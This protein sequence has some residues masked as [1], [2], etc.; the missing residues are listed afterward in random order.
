MGYL[1]RR[2]RRILVAAETQREVGQSLCGCESFEDLSLVSEALQAVGSDFHIH[3]S[4]G[5]HEC[6]TPRNLRAGRAGERTAQAKSGGKG[7]V[8]VVT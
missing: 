3:I 7:S 6:E 1:Q 4:A 2:A 5:G 8:I